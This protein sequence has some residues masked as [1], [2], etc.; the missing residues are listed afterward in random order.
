MDRV[1]QSMGSFGG[2]TAMSILTID[3][4][5]VNDGRRQ[6]VLML[7]GMCS[8][9]LVY[10]VT[11]G[12]QNQI[13][14][15]KVAMPY[16]I[17][18]HGIRWI[19][20][21]APFHY[22]LMVYGGRCL[23]M[24]ELVVSMGRGSSRWT[25]AIH[26]LGQVTSCDAWILAGSL[27]KI[28]WDDRKCGTLHGAFVS[29]GTIHNA[30]SVFYFDP[31]RVT[32]HKIWD[33]RGDAKV[34]LYSMDLID[35]IELCYDKEDVHLGDEGMVVTVRY[36]CKVAGG[37]MLW[38]VLVWGGA[39]VCHISPS[40]IVHLTEACSKILIQMSSVCE[41]H[42]GSI[43]CLA[44]NDQGT[45]LASGSDDRVVKVWC[46][47]QQRYHTLIEF[48]GSNSR[49]WCLMFSPS[50][51]ILF[52]GSEDG[53]IYCWDLDSKQLQSKFRAHAYMG[54]RA[55]RLNHQFIFSGGA[56]GFIKLWNTCDYI[57]VNKVQKWYSDGRYGSSHCLH[58][59][60]IPVCFGTSHDFQGNVAVLEAIAGDTGSLSSIDEVIL[61]LLITYGEQ[62]REAS[63]AFET[64][65]TMCLTFSGDF[66]LLA[67]DKGR[68][69]A[70][71]LVQPLH[72]ELY[73]DVAI[74]YS[75]S[76]RDSTPIVSMKQYRH[77]DQTLLSCCDARGNVHI[78]RLERCNSSKAF[79]FIDS[80][81][82][83]R[84]NADSRIIDTFFFAVGGTVFIL[85]FSS[86]G[87]LEVHK[88]LLHSRDEMSI[89]MVAAAKCPLGSRITAMSLSE[90][91]LRPDS[92]AI[93]V[94][95]SARGGVSVWALDQQNGLVHLAAQLT[96]HDETPVQY[97][98]LNLVEDDTY[99]LN[100]G[101]TNFCIQNYILHI[102][103]DYQSACLQR[104]NEYRI[105]S[106][107]VLSGNF[108]F[109]NSGMYLYGFFTNHFIVWDIQMDA[110][111][112]NV[113]CAGWK[114]PWAFHIDELS[115]RMVFCYSSGCGDIHVY[116]RKFRNGRCLPCGLVSGGHGREIN[117]VVD[118]G[119]GVIIT[120]G[121]DA[122]LHMAAWQEVA[123]TSILIS[124]C[125]STQPFGT[126]T[127]MVRALKSGNECL[128]VSGGARSVMTAW[129]YIRNECTDTIRPRLQNFSTFTDR[130][131]HNCRKSNRKV[132]DIDSRVLS[133]TLIP[134][135]LSNT[136]VALVVIALS[137]GVVEL[138]AIPST[139]HNHRIVHLWPLIAE[140]KIKG[141]STCKGT[142]PVL[143]LGNLQG[144]VYAGN[145]NGD[146]I[147]WNI[148][149]CLNMHEKMIE[150]LHVIDIFS[151]NI[152]QTVHSCG[153]NGLC[154][155]S[156]LFQGVLHTI[157][158]TG[159]D[160]QAIAVTCFNASSL[161]G[162]NHLIVPNAHSSAI[163]DIAI[164][165]NMVLS[166][167]LDQYMRVWRIETLTS[168]VKLTEESSLHLQ[169][170]EPTC[171]SLSSTFHPKKKCNQVSI[172]VAGRGIETFRL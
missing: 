87:N 6:V 60:R 151:E 165:G 130:L 143:S 134:L 115:G 74:V 23:G 48:Y 45:R 144:I 123:Q 88:I 155:S 116:T 68:I 78:I 73:R 54:V 152:I 39:L 129:K 62:K 96:A 159:G 163:R 65:K 157:V 126:S 26:P 85:A 7:V 154:L 119:D 25:Y 76:G 51:N 149:S 55:I 153:I 42:K 24:L 56:D 98:Y 138:R 81:V 147:V 150:E 4:Q 18:V 139:V 66:V 8:R 171:L 106:L 71:D 137:S 11:D 34:M 97:V 79:T 90:G 161:K 128:V 105:D 172:T 16:G 82:I 47:N 103:G 113:H 104:K 108:S 102:D 19:R 112:W 15:S 64:V 83:G 53:Y 158:I 57:P 109:S 12:G 9:I 80:Y 121:G 92:P 63:S 69:L 38:E 46:V 61:N 52:S 41:R 141:G 91:K 118:L 127:R 131:V 28:E 20:G 162:K 58:M 49:I 3:E 67:T 160:D 99:E 2:I 30:L 22:Y 84:I 31:R 29:V 167:G 111:V 1:L 156:S 140:L 142:S 125:I 132:T 166:I 101:A 136:A 114:R 107:K 145:T 120:A 70:V 122:T 44:W 110:E 77:G 14:A 33:F 164:L 89:S 10:D 72:K 95:G 75:I 17:R 43:H 148:Q 100:T 117:S 27:K 40:T 146:I 86:L 169:V 93:V 168:R 13:V 94:L 124:H 50:G 135:S 35:T 36:E 37:T 21:R 5:S 32:L 170:L 59:F 133:F